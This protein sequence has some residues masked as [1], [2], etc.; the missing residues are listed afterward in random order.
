M[1]AGGRATRL[2]GV[3]KP[4]LRL[5]GTTLLDRAV[6]AVAAAERIV[7]VGPAQPVH[8]PAVFCREEPPGAGPVAAVAAALPHTTAQVVVLLAADLPEIAPAVPV[9][10]AALQD[11]GAAMLV[12]ASGR[13]NY[14]ASA[15][16]RHD[17]AVA[18]GTIGDPAGAAMHT[19]AGLVARVDVPDPAGWGRDCDT[20]ADL[21]R[22]RTRLEAQ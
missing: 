9:L 6:A 4:Q 13:A 10:V 16:R 17:L 19:L 11:A 18:L 22:A 3:A 1:L 14:L 2:G 8:G 21:D 20:W 12:D 5:S 7:V 15:W